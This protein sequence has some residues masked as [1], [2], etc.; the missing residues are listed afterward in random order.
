[1]TAFLAAIAWHDPRNSCCRKSLRRFTKWG[2][3]RA[4]QVLPIGQWIQDGVTGWLVAN[5]PLTTATQEG[6][7]M[8]TGHCIIQRTLFGFCLTLGLCVVTADRAVAQYD[9][10]RLALEYQAQRQQLIRDHHQQRDALRFGYQ[11]ELDR[12]RV[13]Q[14]NAQRL[15]GHA[16]VAAIQQIAWQRREATERY[17]FQLRELER[18]H[19]RTLQQL[20][21]WYRSAS[22]TVV[23]CRPA[24][25]APVSF[26]VGHHK[27]CAHGP[28][29]SGFAFSVGRGG[30]RI[31]VASHGSYPW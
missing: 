14:L 28:A 8:N 12:L 11:A 31:G 7:T 10:S 13:A 6:I 9:L 22:R 19:V 30:L 3:V 1:M 29:K 25:P 4:R 17:H 18:L 16:R 23:T 27:P 26:H 20:D 2:S 24:P 21:A 15:C 5:P